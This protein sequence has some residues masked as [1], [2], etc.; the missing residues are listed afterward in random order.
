MHKKKTWVCSKISEEEAERISRQAGISKLAA[1]V[2][3]SRGMDECGLIN[4]FLNPTLES[5]HN[6][7]LMKDM[8]KAVDR[9]IQAI[10][11]GER[12]VIYGDYDV[13][14]ITS[15]SILFDFLRKK[16]AHV[17]YY[18]PDRIE[19]GYGIS[20]AGI[21]KIC[22]SGTD[23][24]LTVDCGIAAIDEVRYAIDKGLDIIITDHHECRDVIPEARAVVNPHRSDCNYPFKELAGVGVA[25]KL[26]NA[27]CIKMG[28]DKEYM[29]YLDLAA[30]G[31]IADVVPLIGENRVIAKYGIQEIENTSNLGLRTLINNSGLEGKLIN[32]FGVSFILSP[33]INAAGRLGDAARA[34]KLFT[35]ACEREA[36]DISIELNDE[37]RNRQETET[38]IL[39]QAIDLIE[40]EIDVE[41]EKVIVVA[42]QN[43]HHGVIGIVAS[44]IT[45]RY[46][47][48]CIMLSVE[49]G[50]AKGSGRSIEGLNLFKAL[51][52]CEN[53]LQKYGGHEL[54]VGLTL[55]EENIHAF[56]AMINRY[57]DE[58]MDE[59]D[60]V[61]RIKI[62]AYINKGD[63]SIESVMELEKLAPFGAGNPEPAFA[64]EGLEIGEM[65]TVGNNR[66]LKLKL[67]SEN[68]TFDA[69]GFNMSNL[70]NYFNMGDIIDSAFSLGINTW[71]SECKV[72][73]NLKD[74]KLNE[75]VVRKNEY[76]YELDKYVESF[77]LNGYN[78]G[79]TRNFDIFHSLDIDEVVLERCDLVAIFQY[80]K[81]NC[82]K[83]LVIEDLFVFAGRI[84]NSY[85][86]KM[87]YFKLKKGIKIF[88]ELN[89]LLAEP[90]GETGMIITMLDSDGQKKQLGDSY[91]F[92]R[93]QA[94]KKSLVNSRYRN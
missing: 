54:A 77:D 44:R 11:K 13:D 73:M 67:K 38:D 20:K 55:A 37:N 61:P 82:A 25:F 51:C 74:I 40:K 32:S 72:Q 49:D 46:Y 64:F 92:N 22:E 63:I 7:F 50:I 33:R 48:P 21:D 57:A 84:A 15:T 93:L 94:L 4:D 27:L 89:L 62:D 69:I 19:E 45:E 53:L 23:L 41:K 34:V 12:I 36:H 31:T 14:G 10:E 42:G 9:L 59:S 17:D 52:Y 85:K 88:E 39:N 65:Y 79:Y 56:R 3:L 80:M 47:R 28:C 75:S 87:N 83:T 78:K 18:I 43:W 16:D 6:P 35:T 91:T 86:I 29:N 60:L 58:V 66:H 30:L 71:N 8:D 26:L 90:L 68:T 5:L 70:V 1:K 76:L 24:I 81:A 2:F